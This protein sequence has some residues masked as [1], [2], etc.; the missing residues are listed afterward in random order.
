MSEIEYIIDASSLSKH[1][2]SL[3]GGRLNKTVFVDLN[4]QLKKGNFVS[5]VGTS[6]CG[7]STLLRIIGGLIEPSDGEVKLNDKKVT[8]PTKEMAFVFQ[9]Y[10]NSLLPWR[11]VEQN[12]RLGLEAQKLGKKA[13]DDRV[14][15]YLNMVGL[16]DTNNMYPWQLSGGMQQRVA[17]ARALACEADILLIDEPFGAL[18][19]VTK[20]HLEDE[21]LNI[22]ME[23]G[24]TVILVTHDIDEAIYLSDR[25]LVLAGSPAQIKKDIKINFD[26]PRHQI[27]TRSLPEF[28]EI[29]SAIY[30]TLNDY[31]SMQ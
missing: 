17:V 6:G 29:R 16:Q 15:K 28:V 2:G 12:I 11:N 20:S 9:D 18:D 13:Q 10:N 21:L 25:V 30:K 8:E 27:S 7:K 31:A 23:L 5:I 14:K 26:R 24:I 4:L 3:D 22:W 19:A 1:Y